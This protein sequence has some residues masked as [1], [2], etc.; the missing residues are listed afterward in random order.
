[1]ATNYKWKKMK[2]FLIPSAPVV[3]LDSQ[4]MFLERTMVTIQKDNIFGEGT[5]GKSFSGNL[6]EIFLF[7]IPTS[8]IL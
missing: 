1:M 6:R 8:F 4:C 7:S 5:F 3:N 2:Y